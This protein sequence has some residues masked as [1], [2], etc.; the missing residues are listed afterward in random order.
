[1]H[2]DST[3]MNASP[4]VKRKK[5]VAAIARGLAPP[6]ELPPGITLQSRSRSS[7]VRLLVCCQRQKHPTSAVLD[8]PSWKTPANGSR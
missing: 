1:M 8:G 6:P 2:L 3:A 5:S 7:K 4:Q